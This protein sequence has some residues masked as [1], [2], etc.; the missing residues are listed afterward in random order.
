MF[1]FSRVPDVTGIDVATAERMLSSAGLSAQVE[2]AYSSMTIGCVSEQVPLAGDSIR[3]GEVVY[4]TVSQGSDMIAVQRYVGM[5]QDEALTALAAQGFV[6][7]SVTVVP[8]EQL[9]G[10]VVVQ[11]PD[12]GVS[13]QLGSVIDLMVSGGRVVVPELVGQREEEALSR[14]DALGLEHG[15]TT[16]ELVEDARQDGVVLAQSL[17]KFTEVLPQS[18]IELTVG[19]YD[20]RKYTA[21]VSVNVQVPPEGVSVR[22]TLVGGDGKE[23]D[24]YAATHTEPGEIEL[25]VLLRSETS[26]VMAWRLYLDGSFRSE[27]T[28]V[29]Q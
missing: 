10:T 25:S 13:T 9:R 1:V 21:P 2:Y 19:Y 14:L 5:A 12:I 28:A 15:M 17:D 4:I 24:M 22:V 11:S 3:R 27:A 20:K 16:Y 8:S 29:L 26:G 18:A 6:A 7:G 23:S